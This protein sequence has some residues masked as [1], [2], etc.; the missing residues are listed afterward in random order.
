[1][2]NEGALG[3][4]R[5]TSEHSINKWYRIRGGDTTRLICD[6]VNFLHLVLV[7]D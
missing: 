1:M 5:P 4:V 6:E 7:C 2:F 3:S